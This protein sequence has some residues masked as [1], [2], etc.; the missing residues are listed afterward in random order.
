MKIAVI[1]IGIFILAIMLP[2]VTGG[3]FNFRTDTLEEVF[4]FYTAAGET[5]QT[6]QLGA[7]LWDDSVAY[8]DVSSNETSEIPTTTSYNLTTRSLLVTNLLASTGHILTVTYSTPGLE[9]YT[10]A[11]DTATKIPLAVVAAV[12][13]MPLALLVGFFIK[14]GF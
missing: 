5:N 11:E 7:N 1:F 4:T 9:E 10:G 2:A 6:V 14:R 12:I 3:L 8:A 13:I